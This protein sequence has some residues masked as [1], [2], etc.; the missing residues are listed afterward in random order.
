MASRSH[1]RGSLMGPVVLIGAGIIFLLNNLGL[2][3][4]M[5]WDTLWR[6]W[7]VLLIAIGLDILVGRRSIWGSALVA[8]LLVAGLIG[9]IVWSS[10]LPVTGDT[11]TSETIRQPLQGATQAE[12][13]IHFGAG[14]LHLDALPEDADLIQ[15]RIGLTGREEVV[16]DFRISGDTAH[17]ELRSRNRW[18]MPTTSLWRDDKSWDLGLNRDVPIDLRIDTGAGETTLDLAQLNLSALDVNCGVGQT[19]IIL[20]RRGQLAAEIDTGIGEVRITIPAGMAARVNVDTGIGGVTVD[21]DLQ[22]SGD[23]YS[24]TDYGSAI[25]RVE[26][27]VDG[28]IGSIIL[29]AE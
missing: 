1:R 17:Y 29:V 10:V 16:S 12:V 4:W 9:A 22:R 6:L 3:S 25:E 18:T 21:G 19:T 14:R 27:E 15:G 28:G 26:L 8:L 11:L 2:L 13:E 5:I 24:T 20:P 7:P 23:V